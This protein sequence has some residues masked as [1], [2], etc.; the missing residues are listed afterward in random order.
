MPS[1]V[2]FPASEG[3]D[4]VR[5]QHQ[6]LHNS[7][8]LSP[9]QRDIRALQWVL[10]SALE[11]FATC[12]L[13]TFPQRDIRALQ[14]VLVSAL[15]HFV[16]CSLSTFLRW[17]SLAQKNLHVVTLPSNLIKFVYLFLT[18]KPVQPHMPPKTAKPH[19]DFETSNQLEVF[20]CEVLPLPLT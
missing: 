6:W 12:S 15:K 7:L 11:H 17:P 5:A 19:L 2:K 1:S 9:M 3:S 16:I 18:S 13:P 4:C 8:P 10:V 14:S 20:P